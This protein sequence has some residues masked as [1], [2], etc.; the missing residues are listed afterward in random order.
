MPRFLEQADEAWLYDN[1][2]AT[3][4]LIGKKQAGVVT[5]DPNALPAIVEAARKIQ[6]E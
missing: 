2:G 6:T 5:L 4:W 1:S 3:P